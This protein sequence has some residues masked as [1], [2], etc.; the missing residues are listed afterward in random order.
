MVKFITTDWATVRAHHRLWLPWATLSRTAAHEPLTIGRSQSIALV[1]AD[2][3][4]LA[5]TVVSSWDTE[6]LAAEHLTG[7]TDGVQGVG[8]RA[9]FGLVSRPVELD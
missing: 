8:L 7:G 6:P 9:V 3:D 5:D 2:E 4:R 1:T